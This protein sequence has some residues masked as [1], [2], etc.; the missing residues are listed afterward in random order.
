MNIKEKVMFDGEE[1]EEGFEKYISDCD[2]WTYD[3]TYE[4]ISD[5]LKSDYIESEHTTKLKD[6]DYA[7]SLYEYAKKEYPDDDKYFNRLKIFIKKD[8]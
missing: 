5:S 4:T 8:K 2:Y 7:T 3:A 6:Q 1:F